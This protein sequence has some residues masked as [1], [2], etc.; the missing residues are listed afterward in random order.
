METK[1][2]SKPDLKRSIQIEL[3]GNPFT[4]NFPNMGQI[5]DIETNKISFA[6]GRYSQLLNSNIISSNV[7]QDLVEMAATLTV[8]IPEFN[9]IF[10]LN[11]I[12][13]LNP[14]DAIEFVTA[15]KEQVFPW[16]SE[17]LLLLKIEPKLLVSDVEA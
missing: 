2:Q 3:Q 9:K 13:E 12:F 6:N 7:A 5:I 1:N 14:I 16:Y 8:L 11:S 10:K 17:W 4:I 15:Y